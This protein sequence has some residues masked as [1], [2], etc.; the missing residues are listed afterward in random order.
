VEVDTDEHALIARDV[1]L[2]C[3]DGLTR[4]VTEPEIAGTLQAETDP[5][6]AAEKLVQLANENGGADNITVIV[7]RLDSEAKGLFSW[8]RGSAR[9]TGSNGDAGG[10]A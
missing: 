8:L 2:I 9:K 3:S 4:M 7:V 5:Q 1:L 6:Q 10:G